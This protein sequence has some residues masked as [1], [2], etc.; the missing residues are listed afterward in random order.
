MSCE[1]SAGALFWRTALHVLTRPVYLALYWLSWH[2]LCNLCRYG[3]VY[4][5]VPVLAF[6]LLWWLCAIGYGLRLWGRYQKGKCQVVFR[7]LLLQEK[8]LALAVAAEGEE[9]AC[10][11]AAGE[12]KTE[13]QRKVL[14][15]GAIKWYVKRRQFCQFFLR[16]KEVVLLDLRELTGEEKD[17]LDVKLSA[18]GVPGKG[19]WRAAAGIF[20]TAVTLQGGRLA[21]QSAVPF[22]GK[23]AWFLEDLKYKRT[24]TLEHD[25]V[26]EYGIEGVLEDVREKAGLPKDLCLANSFSLHFAP[27]GEILTLDTML[28]G[29]DEA[30]DFVDSYLIS[31]NRA[32]S[33]K[34]TIYL[35]GAAEA[36]YDESRALDPLVEAV[37]VMPLRETVEE[38]EGEQVFGLLCCGIREWYSPEGIRLLSGDG[39]WRLPSYGEYSFSGYSISVFCPENADLAPVRYLPFKAGTVCP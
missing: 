9:A 31:Y 18:V 28:Y 22:Q 37:R 7:R 36:A 16:G 24:C 19:L 21:A 14:P 8:G 35:H 30:G 11:E 32:H 4:R 34:L 13:G 6:C 27:D 25:N 1:N 29:F 23:L 5:N 26:Y 20:L 15:E 39:S 12:V 38:W 33:G 10:K 17:F 2:Y 3:Q